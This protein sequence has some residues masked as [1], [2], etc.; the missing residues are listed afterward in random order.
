M[1]T[2]TNRNVNSRAIS[3]LINHNQIVPIFIFH[4]G[5]YFTL[6]GLGAVVRAAAIAKS[7]IRKFAKSDS[8]TAFTSCR[9]FSWLVN[10]YC[11]S[12]SIFSKRSIYHLDCVSQA[13]T[14][15]SSLYYSLNK[16]IQIFS[17][18][19]VDHLQVFFNKNMG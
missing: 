11:L 7:F 17:K 3:K 4:I 12:F 1:I 10:N 14:L 9:H 13:Y 16:Q 2:R 15:G 8:S 5:A 6:T 19:I 18:F